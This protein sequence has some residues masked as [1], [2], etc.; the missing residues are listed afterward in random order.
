M[1]VPRPRTESL[2]QLCPMLWR[3]QILNPLCHRGNPKCIYF[4]SIS[5]NV[6]NIPLLLPLPSTQP[7]SP[8]PGSDTSSWDCFLYKC[9]SYPAQAHIPCWAVAIATHCTD[10][11]PPPLGFRYPAWASSLH[12]L[13]LT[14]IWALPIQCSSLC[15]NDTQLWAMIALLCSAPLMAFGRGP[16]YT[17][18]CNYSPRKPLY[19]LK[20]QGEGGD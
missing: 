17:H 16:V 8:H 15:F 3:C 11:I 19:F 7:F 9:P 13:P 4:W 2:P 1:E 6:S 5:L 12:G 14:F 10:T 18:Y 20:G